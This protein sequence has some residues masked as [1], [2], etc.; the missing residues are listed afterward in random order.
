MTVR[1]RKRDDQKEKVDENEENLIEK[2][3][4]NLDQD[5]DDELVPE[6]EREPAPDPKRGRGCPTKYKK[7]ATFSVPVPAI[8]EPQYR[9]NLHSHSK[10]LEI[11][12]QQ[13]RKKKKNQKKK[14]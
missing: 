1:K 9:G 3:N 8:L 11:Y 12:R 4:E 14:K 10:A 6:V 2:L 5:S 13:K 7:T